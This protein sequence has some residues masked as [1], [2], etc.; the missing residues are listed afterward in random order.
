MLAPVIAAYNS[1]TS[2]TTIDMP[3]I[4][5]SKMALLVD[6]CSITRSTVKYANTRKIACVIRKISLPTL[7]KYGRLAKL[8]S[9]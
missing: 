8:I 6:F 7:A 5:H 4:L 3:R 2:P 9:G 1:T